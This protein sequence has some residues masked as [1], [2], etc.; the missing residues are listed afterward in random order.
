M[1]ISWIELLWEGETIDGE[2]MRGQLFRFNG[3]YYICNN[4][5]YKYKECIASIIVL[6]RMKCNNIFGSSIF[7]MNIT[8][9]LLPFTFL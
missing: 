7:I 3:H 8:N 9:F 1:D 4:V 6:M 5:P 2:F